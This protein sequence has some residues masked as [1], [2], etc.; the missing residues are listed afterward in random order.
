[1]VAEVLR[2]LLPSDAA[3][4]PGAWLE[5]NGPT[6]GS[7]GGSSIEVEIRMVRPADHGVLASP[8]N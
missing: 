6:F 2:P 1:M 8:R 4:P 5:V 7:A 3:L